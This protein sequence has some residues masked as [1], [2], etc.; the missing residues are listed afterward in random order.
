MSYSIVNT[1]V[2]AFPKFRIKKF[3]FRIKCSLE[4]LDIDSIFKE[5]YNLNVLP[6][7][8]SN[9]DKVRI[10]CTID[11]DGLSAPIHVEYAKLDNVIDKLST[12]S[13]RIE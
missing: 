6:T 3:T 12:I 5:L 1:K 8:T 4:N 13:H 2:E 7:I 10:G 9:N 11:V